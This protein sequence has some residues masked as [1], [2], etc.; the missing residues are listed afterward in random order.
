MTESADE[1]N[2]CMDQAAWCHVVRVRQ[3]ERH[4]QDMVDDCEGEVEKG[5]SCGAIPRAETDGGTLRSAVI[6]HARLAV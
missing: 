3:C 6:A 2:E 4:Q 1:H 5:T